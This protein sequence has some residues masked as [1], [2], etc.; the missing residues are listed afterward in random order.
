MTD[1]RV[2]SLGLAVYG[3]TEPISKIVEEYND[4]EEEYKPLYVSIGI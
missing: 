1:D 3:Q 2:M 4:Q